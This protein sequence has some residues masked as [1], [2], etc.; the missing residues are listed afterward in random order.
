[1]AT[2][3]RGRGSRER[4]T[5]RPDRQP[6]HS[7]SVVGSVGRVGPFDPQGD[8]GEVVVE[9]LARVVAGGAGALLDGGGDRT[10][11]GDDVGEAIEAEERVG[12]RPGLEQAVAAQHHGEALT[13]EGG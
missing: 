9:A 13:V 2:S 12:R 4:S 6:S 1:M 5:A 11:T 10:G 8:D 3:S 7:A